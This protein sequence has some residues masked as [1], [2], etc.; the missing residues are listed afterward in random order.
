M[1]SKKPTFAGAVLAG[2]ASRRMGRDKAKLRVGGET[3]VRRQVRALRRAGA[4][5]IVIVRR[6]GQRAAMRGVRHVHDEFVDAGPLAGLHAALKAAAEAEAQWV[7][8][9]AVDMPMADAEW[10]ERQRAGC[11]VGAGVVV[12]H[13]NGF[14]PL[15]AIYPCEALRA[16]E[17]RLR[18]GK[19]SMQA[20]VAALVRQRKMRVTELA[21]GE[22]WRV[23]NWNRPEDV[24]RTGVRGTALLGARRTPRQAPKKEN[25]P[26][27]TRRRAFRGRTAAPS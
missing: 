27:G 11:R 6:S 7:A 19:F 12:R 15:A 21:E 13:A 4:E 2:G 14:E 10:F 22:R 9:L 24:R 5:P 26:T 1:I 17:R 25:G 23:E 18:R 3:L 16:V 20:L 8:V